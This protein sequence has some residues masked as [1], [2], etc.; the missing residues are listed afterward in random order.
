MNA[1]NYHPEQTPA[2]D[3]A[4]PVADCCCPALLAVARCPYPGA[5]PSWKGGWPWSGTS[6]CRWKAGSG[7]RW[8]FWAAG[9][10]GRGAAAVRP[11]AL[12]PSRAHRSCRRHWRCCAG[13]KV[14]GRGGARRGPCPAP[15][16]PAGRAWTAPCSGWPGGGAAPPSAPP[17][18]AAPRPGC[19][20]WR[21][22]A[23]ARRS[24]GAARPAS[25]GAGGAPPRWLPRSRCRRRQGASPAPSL[26]A[27]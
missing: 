1:A 27:A 6:P 21:P 3:A 8:V 14:A 24:A 20:R 5:R 12:S 17:A 15:A 7:E 22:A 2:P 26:G 25:A 18:A 16:A 13:R 4:A 19:S 10:R 11:A 23:R 9:H